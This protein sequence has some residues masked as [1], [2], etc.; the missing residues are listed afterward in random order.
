MSEKHEMEERLARVSLLADLSKRQRGKL[1]SLS[2]VVDH[3]A[4]SEVA[5]QGAGGLALHVI[6]QGSAEVNVHGRDVRR[7]SVGDY[8]GEVSMV[9]GKPRSATV[10]AGADGLQTLAV[11]HLA[12]MDMVAK[13]PDAAKVLM[14]ALCA[15]LRSAEAF[16][17]V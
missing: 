14:L 1:A 8:F 10:T 12:F 11:P 13:D 15:R 3:R 16:I 2:R 17:D 5:A 4:G 7:L 6:L 9:D